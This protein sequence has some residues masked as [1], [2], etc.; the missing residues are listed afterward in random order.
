MAPRER[1]P[2]ELAARALCQLRGLPEDTRYNGAPMWHSMV[3]EAMTVLAAALPP[4]DL[5][6]LV[7]GH[8][9]PEL[10]DPKKRARS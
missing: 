4:D 9:F 6:R 8:P 2:V 5:R 1:P 10:D 7:P 3:H